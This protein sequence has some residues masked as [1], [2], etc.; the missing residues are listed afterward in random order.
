[1]KFNQIVL[2]CTPTYSSCC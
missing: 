2:K 1:L